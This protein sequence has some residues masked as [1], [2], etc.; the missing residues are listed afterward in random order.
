MT[1][2]SV[3]IPS[4]S[5]APHLHKYLDSVFCW[6]DKSSLA[7]PTSMLAIAKVKYRVKFDKKPKLYYGRGRRYC[8]SKLCY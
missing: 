6:T 4:D 7:F 3:I 2:V 1:K 8:E 5:H